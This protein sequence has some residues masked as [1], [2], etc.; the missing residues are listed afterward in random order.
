MTHIVVMAGSLIDKSTLGLEFVSKE[1]CE[2]Q[3]RWQEKGGFDVETYSIKTRVEVLELYKNCNL[4]NYCFTAKAWSAF[5]RDLI[6]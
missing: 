2:R 5:I 1:D 4:K 6:K 3:I